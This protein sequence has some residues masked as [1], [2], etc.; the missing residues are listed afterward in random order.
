MLDQC[1]IGSIT[2]HLMKHGINKSSL[3]NFKPYFLQKSRSYTINETNLNIA[4]D[5]I[6]YPSSR[7]G[8]SDVWL[9]SEVLVC[10]VVF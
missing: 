8:A 1:L 3:S 9:V 7:N 2:I 10:D 6:P 5:N 4:K